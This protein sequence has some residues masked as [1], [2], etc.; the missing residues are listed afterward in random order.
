M[1]LKV[2]KSGVLTKGKCIIISL[3]GQWS[4]TWI[5]GGR[6]VRKRSPGRTGKSMMSERA[7]K[8]YLR[9]IAHHTKN[10][11]YILGSLD[12]CKTDEELALM[13]LQLNRV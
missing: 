13:T 6:P 4:R 5:E 7:I 8:E 1:H 2:L 11:G 10:K 9:A 3:R 12:R